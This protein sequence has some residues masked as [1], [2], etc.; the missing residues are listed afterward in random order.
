MLALNIQKLQVTCSLTCEC[1]L[2]E[3]ILTAC[4]HGEVCVEGGKIPAFVSEPSAQASLCSLLENGTW[5]RDKYKTQEKHAPMSALD[6]GH[7]PERRRSVQWNIL[8]WEPDIYVLCTGFTLVPNSTLPVPAE[9]CGLKPV[10]KPM[11][12][13]AGFVSTL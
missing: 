13:N 6:E 2:Y 12:S 10:R 4:A 1:G 8:G 11:P 3:I 5:A 7:W 9:A